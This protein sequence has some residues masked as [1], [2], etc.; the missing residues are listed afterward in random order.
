MPDVKGCFLRLSK[1]Q[2]YRESFEL[3]KMRYSL[4]PNDMHFKLLRENLQDR[5]LNSPSE[6]NGKRMK[7]DQEANEP[8]PVQPLLAGLVSQTGQQNS[9]Q[10]GWEL[11]ALCGIS[12]ASGPLRCD[13]LHHTACEL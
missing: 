2:L 3:K 4:T 1:A 11:R 5:L 9:G 7:V 6:F 12:G 10:R 8:P 13:T